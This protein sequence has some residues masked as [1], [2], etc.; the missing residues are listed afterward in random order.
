MT[1]TSS[2]RAT[3]QRTGSHSPATARPSTAMMPMKSVVMPALRTPRC[4]VL[5]PP[6]APGDVDRLASPRRDG[7]TLA[8]EPRPHLPLPHLEELL[9][10]R[11]DLL[12]VDLVEPGVD[13]GGDGLQVAVEVRP[14]R[15]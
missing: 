5:C 1:A 13:V 8:G 14:A 2:T 7:R 4:T 11:P 6:A 15:D 12:H 10:E 9:L 3:I